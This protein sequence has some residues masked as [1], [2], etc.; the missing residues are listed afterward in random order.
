[1]VQ[2][3]Q[4]ILRQIQR[5]C[6]LKWFWWLQ[7]WNDDVVEIFDDDADDF[8]NADDDDNN[9]CD[10]EDDD[11]DDCDNAADDDD[12]TD[13]DADDDAVAV[14]KV[15]RACH[16]TNYRRTLPPQCVICAQ[17]TRI[18]QFCLVFVLLCL[19]F[20]FVYVGICLY[21]ELQ[22]APPSTVCVCAVQITKDHTLL[23]SWPWFKIFTFVLSCEMLDQTPFGWQFLLKRR[24]NLH[25][26]TIAVDE[27]THKTKSILRRVMCAQMSQ[28]LLQVCKLYFEMFINNCEW[29]T[30]SIVHIYIQKRSCK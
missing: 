16:K 20:V 21:F 7:W 11:D 30:S 28:I 3:M 27:N 22:A 13:G 14:V 2:L 10:A 9:D 4:E 8:D 17:I 26:C 6:W 12:N 29:R 25:N 23:A 19:V 1:M 18:I 5:K 24:T 15:G